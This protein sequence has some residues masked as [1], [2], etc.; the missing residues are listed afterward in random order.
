MGLRTSAQRAGPIVPRTAGW[1]GDRPWPGSQRSL[2]L[3]ATDPERPAA[4]RRR[5]AVI[6]THVVLPGTVT[7]VALISGYLKLYGNIAVMT[8][9]DDI[10][11]ITDDELQAARVRYGV[12]RD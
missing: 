3:L 6:L 2:D 8:M 4:T 11:N 9:T 12:E 7:S 1:C 10:L 5:P